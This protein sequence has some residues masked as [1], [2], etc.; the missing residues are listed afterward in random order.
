[1]ADYRKMWESLGLD[2]VSHDQ[3]MNVLPTTYGSVYMS[4]ENRPEGME[5]FDFVVSEV[6]GQRIQE[7]QDH[8][9]AG[10]KVIGAFCVYVP[11]EIVRAAG[12]IQV[13]LCS[14]V[15]IGTAQA[16]KVLPR[17]ICPL[18]KSFM[19]FKL[20]KVCPYFES[21]NMVVGETTCDG[22]KKAFEILN[23]FVPVQQNR[24]SYCLM[25]HV[26]VWILPPQC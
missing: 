1:M 24:R 6:H 2:L 25:S 12:G 10:G 9:A 20:G 7:L 11:E 13:G 15:E 18:I 26:P 16:E 23:D 22:K 17:N 19:G 21:C 4:Q 8:K 3:L 14:G 5:Y